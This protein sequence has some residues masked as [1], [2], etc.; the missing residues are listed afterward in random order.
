MN[1]VSYF[2]PDTLERDND[3]S[4]GLVTE[5][6]TMGMQFFA[7]GS[8]EFDVWLNGLHGIKSFSL[9]ID[10]GSCTFSKEMRKSGDRIKP[11]WYASKRVVGKL[12]RLYFGTDFT[13]DKLNQI[14]DRLTEQPQPAIE[15][16]GHGKFEKH[17]QP[18]LMQLAN[19]P[20]KQLR[21]RCNELE[22]QNK[23]LNKNLTAAIETIDKLQ[24][25]LDKKDRYSRNAS[26]AV[27]IAKERIE[28]LE[29]KK[30]MQA[31]LIKSL[32][33][34]LFNLECESSK[35]EDD[36]AGYAYMYE[37]HLSKIFEYQAMIEKY[38]ALATGKNKKAHPR[39]AYLIDF[40][41]E[42]DKLS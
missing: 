24:A 34:D 2:N 3:G 39:Y 26:L 37:E 25:D 28:E 6:T 9:H 12:K 27:S 19:E 14:I 36:V 13:K 30:E 23:D 10:N 18:S 31:D 38:R 1:L 40:I 16:A 15:L 21:H 17:L 11:Y 32:Q 20:G 4:L 35:R 22:R 29:S 41:A 7:I 33:N 5:T 42:I 8:I